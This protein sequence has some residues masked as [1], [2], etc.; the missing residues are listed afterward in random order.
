MTDDLEEIL[1]SL[2]KDLKLNADRKTAAFTNWS[3]Q[4]PTECIRKSP[5]VKSLTPKFDKDQIQSL[6][7][8][9]QIHA[10]EEFWVDRTCK[11]NK[12]VRLRRVFILII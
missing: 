11:A 10:P 12:L 2:R 4:R 3:F 1:I 5:R 8:E 9:N 6:L 7:D